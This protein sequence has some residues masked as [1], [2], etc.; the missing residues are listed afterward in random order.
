MVGAALAGLSAERRSALLAVAADTESSKDVLGVVE[1]VAVSPVVPA[2]DEPK[3]VNPFDPVCQ[4]ARQWR[5]LP[6]I[7]LLLQ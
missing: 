3:D 2:R 5:S 1:V 7:V 6:N 4:K